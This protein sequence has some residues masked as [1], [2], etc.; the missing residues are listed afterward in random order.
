MLLLDQLAITIQGKTLIHP[1]QLQLELGQSVAILGANGA[2]KSTLLKAIGQDIAYTGKIYWQGQNL[3]S[4]SLTELSKQVIFM[5]QQTTLSF[6][7][8]V[9]DIVQM[10]C[11]MYDLSCQEINALISQ[12]LSLFDIEHLAEQNYLLL[13][14]GEK[15]RVQAARVWVQIL[16]TP[17]PKLVL[18]DE[19]TSAL[20]LKHQHILLAQVQA[21][22]E[23]RHTVLIVL[24]DLNL[25][26]RYCHKLLLLQAKQLLTC[27]SPEKAL[28]QQNIQLTYQYDAEIYQKSGKVCV[29]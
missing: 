29:W 17:T 18:L 22:T 21:L 19:P 26:S 14:G 16:A 11:Q 4:L 1:F 15:Q 9:K 3:A 25:A 24:H 10:G 2:G 12:A 28:T 5:P 6:A 23:Q 13:S 8:A 7:F 20:D 27:D